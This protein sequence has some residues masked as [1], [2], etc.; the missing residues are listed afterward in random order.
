MC[1]PEDSSQ[2]HWV[3]QPLFPRLMHIHTLWLLLKTHCCLLGYELRDDCQFNSVF[4][5]FS[6]SL[7]PVLNSLSSSFLLAF[8]DGQEE[9]LR[10]DRLL[11]E[12]GGGKEKESE[13]LVWSKDMC[14]SNQIKQNTF[15]DIDRKVHCLKQRK[16][17][18]ERHK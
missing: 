13:K 14:W 7:S 4:T 9:S 6:L 16:T 18:W 11:W 5:H 2:F 8:Y 17:D 1:N 10:A 15:G 12:G 3:I